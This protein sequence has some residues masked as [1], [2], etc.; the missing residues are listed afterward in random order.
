[1]AAGRSG[2]LAGDVMVA[3][4]GVPINSLAE[5]QRQTKVLRNRR[6]ASVAVMRKGKQQK[7]GRYV[8]KQRN[9]VIQSDGVLGFAQV[10]AA[11]MIVAGDPPPHPYRGI[12]TNCHAIGEGWE[13]APDPDLINLPPPMLSQVV[14]ARGEPPHRDFGP[15]R[16]C[17]IVVPR[18][19]VP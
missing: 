15:C 3:V 12:C 11:P 14:V 6:Q 9:F 17:H 19:V 18:I 2:M 8:M 10:E 16:A 5:F 4:G 13:L 1:M 7:N